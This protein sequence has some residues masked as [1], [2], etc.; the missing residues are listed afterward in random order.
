MRDA[1]LCPGP[2][3]GLDRRFELTR[4]AWLASRTAGDGAPLSVTERADAFVEGVQPALRTFAACGPWGLAA[5]RTPPSRPR[6]G[7]G[8]PPPGWRYGGTN[9]S[10]PPPSGVMNPKPFASLNHFTVPVAIRGN[11][12]RVQAATR[13]ETAPSSP[14]HVVPAEAASPAGV[15]LSTDGPPGGARIRDRGSRGRHRPSAHARVHPRSA[16]VSSRGTL[17]RRLMCPPRAPSKGVGD[18]RP[19]PGPAVRLAD[20]ARAPG[21]PRSRCSRSRSEWREHGHLQRRQR[22]A[23]APAA[24]PRRG[25]RRVRMALREGFDPFGTSFLDYALYRDQARSFA[26][27]GLATQRQSTWSDGRTPSR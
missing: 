16:S 1:G 24:H 9:T 5:A 14:L 7:C 19:L 27:T 10:L 6:R 21:S 13:R 15:R 18:G 3:G 26:S 25:R 17:A 11:F 22:A 2:Y 8:S 12:F 20:A 4:E 23:A